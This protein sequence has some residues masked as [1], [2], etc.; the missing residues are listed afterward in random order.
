[1][2]EIW[3]M[4]GA[5][6]ICES[7]SPDSRR[8]ALLLQGDDGLRLEIADISSPVR[9]SRW[10][11]GLRCSG[12]GVHAAAA[13]GAHGGSRS[14]YE[15]ARLTIFHNEAGCQEIARLSPG[16]FRTPAWS[17][18]GIAARL[19]RASCSGREFSQIYRVADE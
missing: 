17:P 8:I 19:R 9:A 18:D 16:E 13:R 2:H 7:W 12:R 15:D 4:N 11:A 6:P 5:A 1:M 14:V 3:R 10:K